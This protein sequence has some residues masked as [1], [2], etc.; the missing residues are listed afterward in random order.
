MN[1]FAS[2]NEMRGTLDCLSVNQMIAYTALLVMRKVINCE[3]QKYLSEKMRFNRDIQFRALSNANDLE[4]IGANTAFGQN[5]L[6]YRGN[7]M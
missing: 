1:K 7:Q 3:V 5:S 2:S 4:L 6:L